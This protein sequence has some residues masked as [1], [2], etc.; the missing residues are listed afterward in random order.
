VTPMARMP[1]AQQVGLLVLAVILVIYVLA[2]LVL[3]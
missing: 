1:R 3:R 2:R